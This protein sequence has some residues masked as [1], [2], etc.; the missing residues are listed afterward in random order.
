M[1]SGFGGT[2]PGWVP[3]H[4]VGAD[5]LDAYA[6]PDASRPPVA[7]IAANSPVRLDEVRGP[8]ARVT[9]SNNW[10]GWVDLK[11][12]AS[13]S[14]SA[15]DAAA[16][17]VAKLNQPGNGLLA[18]AVVAVL[19]LALSVGLFPVLGLP[20][21][22]SRGI[23][24]TIGCWDHQPGSVRMWVCSAHAGSMVLLGGLVAM[25]V[26]LVFMA[27]LAA[28][29]G[30]VA[31]Q[32]SSVLIGP[33]LGTLSFGLVF[34]SAH[35]QTAQQDGIVPQRVFPAVVGIGVFLATRYGPTLARRFGGQLAKRD[36]IPVPLRIL[37]TLA[38]PLALT[39]LTMNQE[40]VSATA[41][42]EQAIVMITMATG[43]AML[44]PRD[45]DIAG[46]ARRLLNRLTR[47]SSKPRGRAAP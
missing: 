34:A 18:G 10:A 39:F 29:I 14:P 43:Y 42:K 33:A 21:K 4:T 12:L 6:T 13:A 27:P 36:R 9:C 22:L 20:G 1:V 38:V 3:T 24:P 7:R 17:F 28:L 47:R 23:L 32:G 30:K 35:D 26:A 31:P 15:S 25:L 44:V 5:G 8:W 16:G 46:A 19:C 2:G 40:R 37:L 41:V 11:R 45:G